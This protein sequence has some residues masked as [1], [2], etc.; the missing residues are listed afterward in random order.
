MPF[1]D[2]DVY[3]SLEALRK[4]RGCTRECGDVELRVS[5]VKWMARPQ[6]VK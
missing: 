4:A 1:T 2:V 3:P 5:L 6:R